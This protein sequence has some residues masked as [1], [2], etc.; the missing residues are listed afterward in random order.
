MSVVT[1]TCAVVALPQFSFQLIGIKSG[2][3]VV[4]II[5]HVQKLLRLCLDKLGVVLLLY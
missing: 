2:E 1:D 5:P 4:C 3:S